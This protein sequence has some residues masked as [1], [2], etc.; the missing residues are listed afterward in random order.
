MTFLR[1]VLWADAIVSGAAGAVMIAGAGLLAPLLGL[2][3]ALLTIAG[4]ALIPWVMGLIALAGM[5]N[6][7]RAGVRA[8]I[9]INAVWVAGSMLV[10]FVFSPSLFGYAFVIAQAVA[11]GAF[12]ELQMIALKREP[13]RA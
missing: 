10:L 13:A 6:V 8:A 5:A 9:A 11:V 7:P 4:V 1:R 2:P 3:Q 12:A